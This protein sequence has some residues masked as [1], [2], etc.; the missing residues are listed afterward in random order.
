MWRHSSACA[1][2]TRRRVRRSHVRI[3]AMVDVEE[4]PLCTFEED[5]FVTL[6]RAMEIHHGVA[7]EGL[8]SLP[9]CHITFV[10]FT[11]TDWFR[12]ER[13]KDSVVLDYFGLQFF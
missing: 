3:G 10:D 12:P 13:L 6:D 11:K 2:A 4:C 9:S 8:Q 7:Y 1:G 5:L